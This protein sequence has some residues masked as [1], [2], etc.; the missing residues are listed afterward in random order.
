MI[1]PC[2]L[3]ATA[4]SEYSQLP[5]VTGSRL[6]HPQSEDAAYR[7]YR[8]QLFIKGGVGGGIACINEYRKLE[9][10]IFTKLKKFRFLET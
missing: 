10:K 3:S 4:Y 2:R 1:T 9:R 8:E 7:R 6:R 5:S